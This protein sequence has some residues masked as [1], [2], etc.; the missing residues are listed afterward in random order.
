MAEAAVAQPS[1]VQ[2]KAT[3][4]NLKGVDFTSQGVGR[5]KASSQKQ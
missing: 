2:P 3:K 4:L 1:P 5:E